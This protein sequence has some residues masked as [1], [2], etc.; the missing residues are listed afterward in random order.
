[1]RILSP[2][3]YNKTGY[4]A[5]IGFFDGLHRGHRFVIEQLKT[6]AHERSL[7]SLIITFGEH[8]RKV[9]Q[10]GFH[11]LL[12]TTP[13]EKLELLGQSGVDAC[14]V[15]DFTRELSLLSAQAFMRQV[16]HKQLD[17]RVLLMGY[18]HRF[19]H[20]RNET[21]TDYAAYG[22][23]L[24]IEV[25]Q[26]QQFSDSDNERISSS[27]I[28]RALQQGDMA[29][30]NRMLGYDYFIDGTVVDGFKVGRTIGFPTANLR[31]D[32]PEKLLPAPGVYAVQTQAEGKI[33]PGML[34]IGTR[35]TVAN[36][37]RTSVEV[38]LIGFDGNLYDQVLRVKFV[39]RIRDER[40]FDSL[41]ALTA[42][43]EQDRATALQACP[44]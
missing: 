17:V 13:Q 12:L 16:L 32:H 37:S 22:R 33:Y 27:E 36:G 11:P 23:E 26:L 18:D 30:A 5:T 44:A 8:P 4:V 24:G 3:S 2:D 19:G 29:M 9:L 20:N 10:P 38:H 31:P 41:Q 14:T 43:L 42:Q 28:R 40:K 21:F 39:Q 1:M 34:N 15:L 35:P 6:V 25:V 7:P